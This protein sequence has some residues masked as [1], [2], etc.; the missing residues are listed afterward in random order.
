MITC[1]CGGWCHHHFHKPGGDGGQFVQSSPPSS[2]A[3]TFVAP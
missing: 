2:C 3:E 1:D